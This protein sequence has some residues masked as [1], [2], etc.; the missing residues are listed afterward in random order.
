MA[1]MSMGWWDAPGWDVRFPEFNTC[2][3]LFPLAQS[4]SDQ[5]HQ[6]V[7]AVDLAW[8]PTE[9]AVPEFCECLSLPL[10]AIPIVVLTFTHGILLRSS[11]QSPEQLFLE[12]FS[13][14]AS[15]SCTPVFLLFSDVSI[16]LISGVHILVHRA[17]YIIVI[18]WHHLRM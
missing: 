11:Y 15:I 5:M 3:P 10:R 2:H 6:K 7:L 18:Y 12:N 1:W 13:R 14:Y 9:S 4:W 17:A 16:C 8:V